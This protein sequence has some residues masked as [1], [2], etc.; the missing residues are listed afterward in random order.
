MPSEITGIEMRKSEVAERL[1]TLAG[2]DDLTDD[3]ALEMDTL[4]AEGVQLEARHQAAL[5]AER[6]RGETRTR[7][8]LGDPAVEPDRELRELRSR[9]SLSRFA[10]AAAGRIQLDG[11]EEEYRSAVIPPHAEDADRRVPIAM[12][13]DPRPEVRTVTPSYPTDNQWVQHPALFNFPVLSRLGISP[14]MIPT[15]QHTYQAVATPPT[16]VRDT[17]IGTTAATDTAVASNGVT[18]APNRLSAMIIYSVGQGHSVAGLDA[19]LRRLLSAAIMDAMEDDAIL[20]GSY[21]AGQGTF[22]ATTQSHR[23]LWSA[24]TNDASGS[25]ELPAQPTDQVTFAD[26]V[27]AAAGLVDGYFAATPQD[28]TIIASIDAYRRA[29]ELIQTDGDELSGDVLM[30]NSGGFIASNRIPG[31]ATSGSTQEK[32]GKLLAVRRGIMSAAILPVWDS[33][34]LVSDGYTNAHTGQVRLVATAFCNFTV[35]PFYPAGGTAADD[36]GVTARLS[37][38]VAA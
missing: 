19:E 36:A 26:V 37:W 20:G 35:L 8:A 29:Y 30:R 5:A 28:V 2:T 14:T 24:A 13:G 34:M 4:R 1:L 15:G 38:R 32:S 9:S 22:N 3:Q 6:L 18:L 25:P 23:T 10:A 17:N 7:Q 27:G 12:L 33:F 11:A 21:T 31:R 16:V